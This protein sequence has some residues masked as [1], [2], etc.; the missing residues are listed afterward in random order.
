MNMTQADRLAIG[1]ILAAGHEESADNLPP[2]EDSPRFDYGAYRSRING[3]APPA[4]RN[5][6][7]F[8]ADVEEVADIG[9]D[10]EQE[11]MEEALR[12]FC[13]DKQGREYSG[14][15]L[16][17]ARTRGAIRAELDGMGIDW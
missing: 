6:A 15:V 2:M 9:E 17:S 10:E 8:V 4:P 1:G 16:P 14:D 13:R 11:D 12:A 5:Y 3:Y 7:P